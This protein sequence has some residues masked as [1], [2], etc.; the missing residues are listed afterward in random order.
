MQNRL[1]EISTYEKKYEEDLNLKKII[2]DRNY[3]TL[4]AKSEL[5]KEDAAKLKKLKEQQRSFEREL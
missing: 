1:D 5:S 2:R 3:S 4:R